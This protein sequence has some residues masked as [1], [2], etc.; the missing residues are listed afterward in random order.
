MLYRLFSL[1]L[2]LSAGC[3]DRSP[4]SVA[5]DAEADE[6]TDADTDADTDTDTDADTDADTDTDA[7]ADTDADTDTSE[8]L[9]A[10]IDSAVASD[11]PEAGSTG[12]MQYRIVELE[13]NGRIDPLYVAVYFHQDDVEPPYDEGFPVVV[14]VPPALQ[15]GTQLREQISNLYRLVE[16]QVIYPGWTVEEMTSGTDGDQGGEESAFALKEALLF[17]AGDR[18]TADGHTI[19]QLIDAPIC[20]RQVAV[21][22]ASSGGSVVMQTLAGWSDE[23]RDVLLGFANHENPSNPQFIVGDIGRPWM[24]PD[25]NADDDG[26]GNPWDEGRNL[27][28]T[29]G[30]CGALECDLD[31]SRLRWDGDINHGVI[32]SQVLPEQDGLFYLDNNDNGQLDFL[33]G[34]PTPLDTNGNR[35]LDAD[36]DYVFV[37]TWD[38]E[39]GTALH[40]SSPQV[41][42]AADELGLFD[43]TDWP[44][45]VSAPVENFEFWT[46]RS[47]MTHVNAVAQRYPESFITVVDFTVNDHGVSQSAHPHILSFYNAMHY[48]G[49]TI[50]YNPSLAALECMMP[51]SFY[52]GWTQEQKY[53]TPL[54]ESQIHSYGLPQSFPN[55]IVRGVAAMQVVWDG[56]GPFANCND[57]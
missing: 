8:Y 2:L 51:E 41:I 32:W 53:N 28:Y 48:A 52:S 5:D 17:A 36:E 29:S 19:D 23:L 55:N 43:E 54:P 7:D 37:P 33:P 35:I 42:R 12:S 9:N 25:E 49:A 4:D 40:Y 3:T 18:T 22:G 10:C 14:A 21:L 13:S 1:S 57:E 20:N 11:L 16:I 6:D 15:V 38:Q 44:S 31:Y 45:S 47:M 46:P 26:N 50:R 56:V 34:A 30:S 24:D 27:V 39:V